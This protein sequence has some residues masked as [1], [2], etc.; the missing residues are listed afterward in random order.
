MVRR[1]WEKSRRERGGGQRKTEMSGDKIN[2][3]DG[4]WKSRLPFMGPSFITWGRQICTSTSEVPEKRK[5]DSN[6]SNDG[7]LF[8]VLEKEFLCHR[9]RSRCKV[10]SQYMCDPECNSE[11]ITNHRS[12]LACPWKEAVGVISEVFFEVKMI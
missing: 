7:L 12:G 5:V 4:T 1:E 6:G 10:Y 3:A 2:A 11:N 8:V 9:K